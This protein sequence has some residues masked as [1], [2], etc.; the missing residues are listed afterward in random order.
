MARAIAR[1][2]GVLGYSGADWAEFNSVEKRQLRNE[3]R[4]ADRR[5]ERFS[6]RSPENRKG[7]NRPGDWETWE[8]DIYKAEM[9][10]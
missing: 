9:G 2:A 10:M 3:V 4:N 5:I 6:N 8:W 1:A 7:D